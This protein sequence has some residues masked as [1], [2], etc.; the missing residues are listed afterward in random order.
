MV[1]IN[2]AYTFPINPNP[3]DSQPTLSQ[4]QVWAGL[5]RK[6]RRAQEFVPVIVACEVLQ[7]DE[8]EG[9][10]RVFRKVQFAAPPG[11]QPSAP[12]KETCVHYPPSRVDFEQENGSTISNIVST[13]PA[14]ELLMTYSFEWKHP[15]VEE[16]S[17]K[18]TELEESHWKVGRRRKCKGFPS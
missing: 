11:S 13:G 14:G 8:V 9:K 6:V 4:R 5:K 18:A 3:S 15:D 7:E 17:A 2:I 16:G 1:A 12:I 10:E